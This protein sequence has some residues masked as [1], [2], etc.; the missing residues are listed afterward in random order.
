[1]I[2]YKAI[3]LA[4]NIVATSAWAQLAT[5]KVPTLQLFPKSSGLGLGLLGAQFGNSIASVGNVLVSSENLSPTSNLPSRIRIFDGLDGNWTLDGSFDAFPSMNL[6]D[7]IV[8]TSVSGDAAIV[9]V[10]PSGD[11][12]GSAIT[13]FRIYQKDLG[14]WSET[15]HVDVS[16]SDGIGRA[17]G[18]GSAVAIDGSWAA[19]GDAV[20][21]TVSLYR[22]SGSGMAWSLQQTLQMQPMDPADFGKALALQGNELLVGMP[23]DPTSEEPSNVGAV[24]VFGLVGG[25]WQRTGVLNPEISE[26]GLQFGRTIAL[27]GNLA[28]IGATGSESIDHHVGHAF[29]FVKHVADG[30][31]SPAG[32]LTASDA[33]YDDMLSLSIATDGTNILAG[34]AAN[35]AY[36][37]TP[38]GSGGWKQTRIDSPVVDG[39]VSIEFGKSVAMPRAGE[40]LIGSPWDSSAGIAGG[41]S[42]Y[43]YSVAHLT[44]VEGSVD[45]GNSDD[46][47]RFGKSIDADG[48][49]V[50]IGIPLSDGVYGDNVGSV[51]VY[52]TDLTSPDLL[53][54]LATVVPPEVRAQDGFGYSVDVNENRIVALSTYGFQVETGAPGDDGAAYIYKFDPST[55]S[56]TFEQRI[57]HPNGSDWDWGKAVALSGDT[58]AVGAEGAPGAPTPPGWQNIASDTGRVYIFV[59]NSATGVWALNQTLTV[60]DI[61]P[62]Y[63]FGAA[64]EWC[65]SRLVVGA[66]F[67]LAYP[68][69]SGGAAY[70][71]SPNESGEYLQ[72]T[73]IV[74]N[75]LNNP[76]A[77]FG[78]S[79]ACTR[80]GTTLG[81]GTSDEAFIFE[82]SLSQ[83]DT[84]TQKYR[85]SIPQNNESSVTG[86]R[87]IKNTL[88]AGVAPSADTVA[89]EVG[90]VHSLRKV[91]GVWE[92]GERF[93]SAYA[94]PGDW[95]GTSIG[96]VGYAVLAASPG[97]NVAPATG[98]GKVE[99]FGNVFEIFS[100]GFDD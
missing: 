98:V 8:A 75:D 86:L 2:A 19:V 63:S 97:E 3:I 42:I 61:V 74:A 31:W 87:F 48:S 70:V 18:F 62:I 22:E 49:L 50:A 58:L 5:V 40:L 59:R 83:P 93:T 44:S 13:G 20:N 28:A 14:I 53:R 33:S 72:Q 85:G 10:A 27:L 29:V 52:V 34:T 76:P 60:T 30:S 32:E 6:W 71:F 79:L 7:N 15:A 43:Q 84:W 21:G 64:L 89:S 100:D 45:M 77:Y 47:E 88:Y 11:E 35:K 26:G 24:A 4:L 73:K 41:G 1:M 94:E 91:D 46:R 39:Q 67:S 96:V 17:D 81:V 23:G 55:D 80:A 37:F 54:H 16:A 99:A 51:A 90:S 66:P 25:S 69:A 68:G 95:L 92:P 57:P 56:V 9:G 12:P 65:G 82:E 78:A 38:N 36:L